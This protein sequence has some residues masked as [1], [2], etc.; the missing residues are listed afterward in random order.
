MAPRIQRTREI[1]KKLCE[2]KN[3]NNCFWTK[4]HLI[5]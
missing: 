4:R 1:R 2:Q 3:D 5:R